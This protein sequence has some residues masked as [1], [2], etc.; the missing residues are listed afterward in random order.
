MIW[1]TD[2]VTEILRMIEQEHFD[3]RT[4]TMGISLRGIA[5]DSI[6]KTAQRLKDHVRRV[7]EPLV[8]T[9]EA[10]QN[11]LAV[12]ITNKRLSVTPIALVGEP[13][14]ASSYLPLAQAMDEVAA[15]V[16]VDYIGGFSAA[17]EKGM[18]PGDRVLIDSIPETLAATSRVCSAINVAST[19]AGI[20]ID[21]IA[22]MARQIKSLAEKTA[23]RGGIGNSKLVVFANAPEDNPFIAGATHGIGEGDLV[24]NVGVSGPGVVGAA[25]KRHLQGN[26]RANLGELCEVIKRQAFK[27]TRAGEL[28][29]R[30]VARR[31]GLPAQF[32]VV[33]LS[34][35][36]TP[37][38]GD[39]VAEILETIGLER[40][41]AP[42]TTAVLAMLTDAVKKGGMMASSSI[43]GL[44]GA[45]IPV[46]EDQGMIDAVRMGALSLEKLEAM[47]AVCSVGLDMVAIPGATH[48]DVIAAIIADE[49][50]IG[51]MN[52]KTTAVRIL[53]VPGAEAGD[54][55]EYGGLLGTAQVMAVNPFDGR[56]FIRRGGR[57][58]APLTSLRN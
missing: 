43:G 14:G 26:P 36:P 41:G 52:N 48:A 42:G 29:G 50:A 45:F 54:S 2:E 16:G 20:N 12:P 35:A 30:E 40:T 28:I 53:P 8:P 15:E 10:L 25:L 23:D 4:V 17:V 38:I 27:V 32:G 19:R 6:E 9:I 51:V 46:S 1:N 37:A 5:T 3:I 33:D 24:I 21:A 57:I 31:L 13:T 18:T 55:Y 58:P 44:S 56:A 49:M 47:T 34:L 7:A 22:L 11:E 39:S